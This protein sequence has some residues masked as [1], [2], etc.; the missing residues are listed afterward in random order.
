MRERKKERT[1]TDDEV[2]LNARSSD[3]QK[4]TGNLPEIKSEVRYSEE[5][6]QLGTRHSLTHSPLT[7]MKHNTRFRFRERFST[8]LNIGITLKLYRRG[9][10]FMASQ[11]KTTN[12]LNQASTGRQNDMDTRRATRAA[13]TQEQ[14]IDTRDHQYLYLSVLILSFVRFFLHFIWSDRARV[15]KCSWTVSSISVCWRY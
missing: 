14:S 7:S 6:D 12:S 8:G 3:L 5:M 13:F 11:T 10:S 1:T 2:I 15:F 9:K 4:M